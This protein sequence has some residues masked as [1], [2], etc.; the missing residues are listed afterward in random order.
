METSV[1]CVLLSVKSVN[2]SFCLQTL[3]LTKHKLVHDAPLTWVISNR[4]Q[5]DVHL[6]LLEHAMVLLQKQED[7]LVL[8]L[9]GTQLVAG[10]TDS[11]R[12]SPLLWLNNVLARNDAT[13]KKAF[14][15]VN[16]SKAGP[17]IYKLLA[18]SADEQKT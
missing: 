10:K 9:Q 13:D 3:D 12:H 16:T 2:F 4:K 14:F 7:R 8:K 11:K 5:I 17:Q 15:V 1:L 18:G 6:V